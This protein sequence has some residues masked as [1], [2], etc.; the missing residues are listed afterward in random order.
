ML[1]ITEQYLEVVIESWFEWDLNIHRFVY[2][3]YWRRNH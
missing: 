3:L 2:F 1:F